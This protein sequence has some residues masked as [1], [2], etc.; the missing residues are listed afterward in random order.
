MLIL[1][2]IAC[3]ET[4][5]DD[6]YNILTT[7]LQLRVLTYNIGDFSGSDFENG[8]PEGAI[9]IRN[10][11]SEQKA[12]IIGLQEDVEGYG[13]GKPD[14]I[15]SSYPYYYRT[16]N[17]IYNYKSFASIWPIYNIGQVYYS[18]GY[19]DHPYFLTG[20]LFLNN[21]KRLLL[22]SFHF[23]WADKNRRHSQIQQ[24]ISFSKDYELAVLMG[25]TNCDNYL[26]GILIDREL[27]YEDEWG[28][29]LDS[30]YSLANGG[31]FGLMPTY[32]NSPLDNIF[33]SSS[34]EI[35]NAFVA[36]YDYMNDHY[37]MVADLYIK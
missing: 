11:L 9:I 33:V 27:L 34:I 21:H 24:L 35:Q 15:Y 32:G 37:M 19:F 6:N 31:A 20:E 16:G 7:P 3:T 23:D 29:F 13:N 36:K 8:S 4:E 28:I 18:G 5:Y 25:D 14:I 17:S 12:S 22:V 30:G 10:A 1:L 2:P 26:E